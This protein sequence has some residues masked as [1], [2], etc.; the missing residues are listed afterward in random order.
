MTAIS[1]QE[2]RSLPRFVLPLAM[3][4]AWRDLRGGIAGF[5]I[6]IACIALGVA[7]IAAVRTVSGSLTDALARE[8]QVL[9]GGDVEASLIHRRATPSEQGLLLPWGEVSEIATL[10]AMARAPDRDGQALIDIKAVDGAYPLFGAIRF[11]NDVLLATA[12]AGNGVAIGPGLAAQ[13]GVQPGDTIRIGEALL[14]VSAIIASEPDAVSG[15]AAFGPRV[16]M[17]LET[18]KATGLDQPGSLIRWHYR[19]KLPDPDTIAFRA[20]M[21][22]PL[23]AAGFEIRD[24][25]D[26]SPGIKRAI[27]R[28]ASFL[29][30]AGLAALLTGGIGVATAVAAFVDRKHKVIAIYKAL[31]APARLVNAA[32]LI[33]VMLFTAIGIAVGI[34]IG[35][36]AP[37]VGI[38]AF[39]ASLPIKLDIGFQPGA[40]LIAA[41]YG[42]LTALV[43]ILWP[44]GRAN[45]VRAAELFRE[46]VT[47]RRSPPPLAFQAAAGLSAA[48]LAAIAVLFSTDRLIALFVCMGMVAVFLLFFA[49]GELI[50]RIARALP[51]PPQPE[52]ALA[53]GNV[54]RPGGLA[55]IITLALGTGL[56]L[57]TAISLVG[58]ALTRELTADL[59]QKAP[60]HFFLG[61]PKGKIERFE[62]LVA[63]N[64]PG[65]RLTT[66]PMLRGR[67]VRINDTPVQEFRAPEEAQ[68]VLN[69]DRG[70]TF[71]ERLPSGS[72]VIEGA[73]WQPGYAGEPLVSFEVELARA[74][75]LK[76]GDTLTVNVLGRNITARLA[77]LRTV[78][79]ES[80]D[81]NFVMIFSPNT[82]ASAPYSLLATLNWEGEQTPEQEA[83]VVRAVANQFPSV[84]AIRVR[85]AL[86]T[87]NA[88]LGRILL[89]MQAAGAVTLASGVL[90]LAGALAAAQ[91]RRIYE[92]VILKTLGATR[93]RILAAHVAEQLFLS[94]MAGAAAALCGLAAAYAITVHIMQIP[95][96]FET[97]KLLQP[98]IIATI[99]ILVFGAVGT[100]QVLRAKAAPYLRSE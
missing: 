59:P 70:L 89:A 93:G 9:L 23:T 67:I 16:L 41:A 57:L 100:R 2:T 12:L 60:S 45:Q 37:M 22:A 29:T 34:L 21:S 7:A 19:I 11:E 5:Y 97:L 95:F 69:G 85:E 55:R 87:V 80:L 94:L 15:G 40:A 50:R 27:D 42:V 46:S 3:R 71:E 38:Q 43:F 78:K 88:L 63:A 74:L 30:L 33:Q 6:F 83:Q 81:I 18:L 8:G 24:R 52:L 84:T 62:A 49:A 13:L 82:L 73:W 90:V 96:A 17:S 72:E 4:L 79:W 53:L 58:G 92:A 64:A 91:R 76:I 68:W 28:L 39:G 75:G 66:A 47:E 10:R 1:T 35:T 54:G 65:A 56:T 14:T 20:G 98:A 36:L 44:L 32:M 86:E 25:N 51:R 26:P 31:G 77:N 61:I 48:A 99:L